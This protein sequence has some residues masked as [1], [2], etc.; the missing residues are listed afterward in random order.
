MAVS[1]SYQRIPMEESFVRAERGPLEARKKRVVAGE[2]IP[3][4]SHQP[5]I[6]RSKDSSLS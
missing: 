6:R 3:D 4:M 1:G 5:P 2:T